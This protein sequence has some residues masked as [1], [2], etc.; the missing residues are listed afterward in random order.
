ME[1]KVDKKVK[2][3]MKRGWLITMLAAIFIF[4]L[5][6]VGFAAGWSPDTAKSKIMEFLGILI[7]ILAAF[8]A[9]KEYGKGKKGRAFAEILGGAMLYFFV[10]SDSPLK[11]LS[12][13]AK[14]LLGF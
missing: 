4:S 13:F 11:S 2:K 10:T 8:L 14:D 1:K 7:V 6:A 5:P 12:E 3:G 9:S